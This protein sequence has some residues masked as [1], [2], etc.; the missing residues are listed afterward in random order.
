MVQMMCPPAG[1]ETIFLFTAFSLWLGMLLAWGWGSIVM[2]A[3]YAARPTADYQAQLQQMQQI[4]SQ[5]ANQSGLPVA[6]EAQALVYEGYMLDARVSAVFLVL[7]IFFIY[8]VSLLRMKN[9]KFIFTQ[10]FGIIITDIY[11]TIGP[12]LPS[13]NGTLPTLIIEPASIGLG[14]AFVSSLLL[15]P[16]STSHV[17]LDAMEKIIDTLKTPLNT[18]IEGPV[19]EKKETQVLADLNATKQGLL[20]EWNELQPMVGFLK[21]DLS[22]GRWNDKDITSVVQDLRKAFI[23]ITNLV[24]FQISRLGGTLQSQK[25]LA[26]EPATTASSEDNG[27]EAESAVPSLREKVKEH[28]DIG[29]HQL[30][31]FSV[32]LKAINDSDGA[33]IRNETLTMLHENS[34]EV[35]EASIEALDS[36]KECFHTVN[37]ARMFSRPSQETQ[38]QHVKRSE[39]A[40]TNLRAARAAFVEKTTDQLLAANAEL[41]NDDGKVKAMNAHL[42]HRFRAVMF[43]MIFE[44]HILGVVDGILPLLENTATHYKDKTRT[45]IWFPA[46]TR[47]I[48]KWIFRRSE[49]AP[50]TAETPFGDPDEI[51]DQSAVLQDRLGIARGIKKR[52]GSKLGRAI[53]SFYRFLVSPD[54]LYAIRMVV[55]SIAVVI[56][57]VIPHTSGFFYR[58]RGLWALIMAQTTMLAYMADFTYSVIARAIGTVVG[59]VLGLVA[60]YIGS[61]NG[62]G[63]AFGLAASIGV[64]LVPILYARVF[65]PR[66]FMMPVIMGA[67]TFMLVVG[68]GYDYK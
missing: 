15:F 58:E 26:L 28:K 33:E 1:I 66:Q 25:A 23:G 8:C 35:I 16:Q 29:F 5:R 62:G 17:T 43:G 34:T 63:N 50:V 48:A 10:I 59:G 60:W 67:A 12:L 9:P 4:A 18:T 54:S 64:M 24:N 45:R 40:L 11:I 47:S 44:E 49:K 2:K 27:E 55:V 61:G 65:L 57:A 41:F 19:E 68:Y 46:R 56:P 7:G 31:E 37:T 36:V 20:G 22:I 42:R 39:T 3:A 14:L 32:F 53:S 51:V 52:P 38:E 30:S 13:F 21:L 6:T